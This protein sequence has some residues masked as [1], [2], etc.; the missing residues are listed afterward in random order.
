M[1]QDYFISIEKN[2]DN[3]VATRWCV[4]ITCA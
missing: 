1:L 4:S 3:Y 2:I